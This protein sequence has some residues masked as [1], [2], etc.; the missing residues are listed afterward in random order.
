M[1]ETY[2][3][4]GVYIAIQ[5]VLT[6]YAQGVFVPTTL[7]ATREKEP[8]QTTSVQ[9]SHMADI[10]Q[11]VRTESMLGNVLHVRVT[12]SVYSWSLSM[13]SLNR[14]LDLPSQSRYCN[15]R[16]A[17]IMSLEPSCFQGF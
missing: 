13:S 1:F 5:A 10:I 16:P 12:S 2:Q 17:R 11:R 9:C 3:F 14:L 8:E 7:E 6:L 15:P 4:T